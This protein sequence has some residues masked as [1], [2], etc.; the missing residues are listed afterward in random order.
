MREQLI[1]LLTLITL[2]AC[3]TVSGQRGLAGKPCTTTKTGRVVTIECPN[4]EPVTVIDGLAG[5]LGPV[6]LPGIQGEPGAAGSVIEPIQ[7][8]PTLGPPVYPT[9]FPEVGL[10]LDS[11][12]YGV[13]DLDASHVFLGEIPPGAYSSTSPQTCSFTVAPNCQ[14]VQQ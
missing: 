6:G 4:S 12:L 10:C 8:C 1:L 9:N 13:Y 14:V 11:K 3:G 5:E 2:A 7:L